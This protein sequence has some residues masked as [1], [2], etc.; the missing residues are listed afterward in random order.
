MIGEKLGKYTIIEKVGSGSMGT[1]YKAENPEDGRLVAIKLVRAKVLYD[2]E[3]RERFLQ[4]LLTA[5]TVRHPGILP[6]LEIGDDEDDFFVITPFLRGHTLSQLL[7]GQPLDWRF[8]LT[9]AASV[10]EAVAAVHAANGA[11]RALK[12]SNIWLQPDG[13][14]VLTDC[15]MARFTEIEGEIT[16]GHADIRHDSADTIIP[17]GALAY[18][19]PEQVRG[20]RVDYRTDIFSLGVVLYEMLT[21]RHPFEARNSFSRIS[22]IVEAEPLTLA[23]RK[24]ALPLAFEGILKRALA[25]KAAERYQDVKQLLNDLRGIDEPGPLVAPEAAATGSLSR[26]RRSSA[27]FWVPAII[28]ILTLTAAAYYFLAP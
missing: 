24:L 15:C 16:P 18:M 11:H 9:V 5:T 8:A 26:N 2:V 6:I 19:S 14:I 3:R 4:G 22:A 20:E 7:H 21:G 13:G 27:R 23:S 28:L 1:V 25:K 17:M 12:P 10:C